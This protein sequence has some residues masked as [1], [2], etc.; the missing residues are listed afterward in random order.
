MKSPE[1]LQTK[2]AIVEKLTRPSFEFI[3]VFFLSLVAAFAFYKLS[4]LLITNE[5][6]G[7]DE[8]IHLLIRQ[9]ASPFID[10][11]MRAVT[12]LGNRQF[13]IF[14][15]LGLLIYYLFIKGHKW[16][17]IKV[18]TVS[19]G[20]SIANLILKEVYARE[21]PS[22]NQMVEVNNFSF[23][24]GH[25]MF[26]MAFYG[27]LIY[28]LWREV[29]SKTLKILICS[30][31]ALLIFAIGISRVYLGVHYASDI[32]A[33]FSAGFLWLVIALST[34]GL[35]QTRASEQQTARKKAKKA[36]KNP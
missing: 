16:Y 29:K 21:R 3:L 28:I 36:N 25:A 33:G 19:I 5:I 22:V 24:S 32:V 13:V 35:I 31:L 6:G 15:V 18:L 14:P 26:S 4:F 10:H 1:K 11:L 30:F 17:S 20:S 12:F 8:S 7:F 9:F 34:V 23:P 27:L 2:T